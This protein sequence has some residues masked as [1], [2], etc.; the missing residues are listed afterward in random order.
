MKSLNKNGFVA[1]VA[2]FFTRDALIPDQISLCKL[3]WKFVL[4]LI[5]VMVLYMVAIMSLFF[6]GNIVGFF[7]ARYIPVTIFSNNNSDNSIMKPYKKWPTI[8][9]GKGENKKTRRIY[10][11]TII[12]P[13]LFAYGIYVYGSAIVSV[14]IFIVHATSTI[15]PSIGIIAVATLGGFGVYKLTKTEFGRMVGG[16][17]HAVH[18]GICPIIPIVDKEHEDE[19]E[20]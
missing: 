8:T 7:T 18:R 11:I 12:G 16:F 4:N 14:G 19:K 17:L 1:Y 2:F 6:V 3:F 10:P 9:L 13:L 5:L 15:A 20:G